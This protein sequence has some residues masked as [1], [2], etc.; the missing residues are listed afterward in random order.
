[1]TG[2]LARVTR[3]CQWVNVALHMQPPHWSD[4]NIGSDEST[5]MRK[6]CWF[7]FSG[8]ASNQVCGRIIAGSTASNTAHGN[9]THS[10]MEA[11]DEVT[12]CNV[13]GDSPFSNVLIIFPME[14]IHL[15]ATMV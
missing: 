14:I 5:T 10:I 1:M 13:M 11:A 15:G 2:L 6:C 12:E 9:P 7:Q 8:S 3:G 4:E